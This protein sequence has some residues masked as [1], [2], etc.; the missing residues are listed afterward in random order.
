MMMEIMDY[1]KNIP[2]IYY[3][4]V[5]IYVSLALFIALFI[6]SEEKKYYVPHLIPFIDKDLSSPDQLINIHDKYPEFRKQDKLSFISLFVRVCVFFM[7]KM[8][9][10]LSL[11]IGC[12]VSLT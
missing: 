2:N 11:S 3:I 8:V 5:G 7:I 6:Y 10:N 12:L 1:M 4:G 9:I